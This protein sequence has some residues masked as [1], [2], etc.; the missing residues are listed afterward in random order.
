MKKIVNHPVYGEITYEEGLWSGKKTVLFN[1]QALK[2][3]NKNSFS[4]QQGEA[5]VTATIRG[6]VL[7]GVALLVQGEEI[8]FYRKPAWYEWVLAV[9]PFALNII[10]GNSTALCSIIPV[11]GG[12]IGGVLNA[13]AM[14]YIMIRIREKAILGKVLISLLGTVIAFGISAALGF[15]MLAAVMG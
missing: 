9:L 15:L 12:A 7:S 14:I 13:I 1:G 10:W 11:V 6:S 3:I 5:V 2:R 4:F 8:W